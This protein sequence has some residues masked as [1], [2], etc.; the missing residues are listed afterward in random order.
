MK[1]FIAGCIG[2]I[3]PEILRLYAVRSKRR[4]IEFSKFYILIS[5]AYILLGGYFAMIFPGVNSEFYG[6]VI[7]VG[8]VCVV[9]TM[10]KIAEKI[11]KSISPESIDKAI[12]LIDGKGGLKNPTEFNNKR[13]TIRK[14]NFWD[15]TNLI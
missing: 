2:A 9:N 13:S 3:A 1:I 8:L 4:T 7:G 14:G 15:F 5:L 10:N 6:A 12:D 11:V